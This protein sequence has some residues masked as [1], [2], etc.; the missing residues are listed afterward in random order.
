VTTQAEAALLQAEGKDARLK[1]AATKAT[2][3]A[4][5]CRAHSPLRMN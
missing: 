5:I 3:K 2:A 4:N 1:A